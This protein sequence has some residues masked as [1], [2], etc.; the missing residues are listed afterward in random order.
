MQFRL[1][2]GAGQCY[3]F[4]MNRRCVPV[5]LLLLLLA[6]FLYACDV[7]KPPPEILTPVPGSSQNPESDSAHTP[8]RP[9]PEIGFTPLPVGVGHIYFV[10]DTGLWRVLPDGSG[11]TKL[12]DLAPSSPPQPSPDGKLVAFISGR[13]LYGLSTDGGQLRKLASGNMVDNQRLG[14]DSSSTLVGFMTYDLATSGTEQAW[15]APAG[16]GNPTL[17]TSL[18]YAAQGRGPTYENTVQW[19]PDNRWV[20]VGGI[21]N[22]FRLLRWPLSTSREGDMRNIPGGEPMWSPDSRT[23][24]FTLSL[25]GALSLYDVLTVTTTP[26][27]TEVEHVGTGL[28]EYANGP[29]PRWSPASTGADSDPLA[30]CSVSSDGEPRVAIRRRGGRDLPTLAGLTNNPSWSPSGDRLVVETGKL[31]DATLGPKW[32]ATGLA[33]A[34]INPSGEHTMSTLLSDGRMP[35]WGR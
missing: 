25:N 7:P 3:T 18:T 35:V 12:T 10:R 20:V 6:S 15:A 21:G 17:I 9:T 22:P 13:T 1:L 29:R 24:L 34:N 33:I 14:W 31:A 11:E 8:T 16:G 27:V 5:S 28:G 30:Y 19:S 2:R 23:I 26:F 32:Q 4:R